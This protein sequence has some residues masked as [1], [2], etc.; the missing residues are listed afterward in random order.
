MD[1]SVDRHVCGR[2]RKNPAILIADSLPAV[3]G[4]RGSSAPATWRASVEPHDVALKWAGLAN[5]RRTL[6]RVTN[7]VS[8]ND[9]YKSSVHLTLLEI[10]K[11]A[12]ESAKEIALG[13]F[14]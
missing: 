4:R 3:A 8:A 7:V 2:E 10:I 12:A 1:S 9:A 11:S 6:S 14:R 5:A 13:A